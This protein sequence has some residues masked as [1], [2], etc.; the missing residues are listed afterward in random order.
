MYGV[1]DGVYYCNLERVQQLSDRMYERNIPSEPL[2]PELTPRPEQT[3]FT[4][5]GKTSPPLP[6]SQQPCPPAKS[7]ANFTPTKIFN[8]GNAQGPW[9]GFAA[10]VN[11]ESTLRNQFFA[12][13]DCDQGK[14]IPSTNSDLYKATI[15]SQPMPQPHPELFRVPEFSPHQPNTCNIARDLFNN[16]TAQQLKDL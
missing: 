16:H 13:Q 1:V 7:Y 4:I 3:K 8:P 10:N 14:Y 11:T 6:E 2:K 9:Y 12:L 5:L 15:I